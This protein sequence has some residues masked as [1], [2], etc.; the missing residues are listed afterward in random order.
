MV[1][2]DQV[3]TSLTHKINRSLRV[4]IRRER[5]PHT[6]IN[7]HPNQFYKIAMTHQNT[8]IDNSQPLYPFHLQIRVHN[9]PLRAV[10]AHRRRPRRVKQRLRIRPNIRLQLRVRIRIRQCGGGPNDVPIPCM[11]G[12]EAL[13]GLDRLFESEDVECGGEEGRIDGW[14][15]EGVGRDEFDGTTCGDGAMGRL[16]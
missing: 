11:R 5:L 7:P 3:R 4:R 8:S 13:H 9:P 16:G 1:R 12:D 6:V 15:G 10:R 2:L 14:R